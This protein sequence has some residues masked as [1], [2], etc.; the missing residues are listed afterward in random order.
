MA[1]GKRVAEIFDDQSVFVTGFSG[2]L[3]KVLVEK[4]LFST[5]VKKV[6]VL[7]R[8]LKGHSPH[9]RLEKI[10]Q[11]PIYDRIRTT[12]DKILQKL[13]PVVGDL[14]NENLG[15]CDEDIQEIS[16]NVS[17]V[18]HCAATV[19]FDEIL[20]VSVQMNLIGTKELIKLCHK[21]DKLIVCSF[22]AALARIDFL[23]HFSQ[24]YIQVQL[25]QIVI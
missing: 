11:S 19:K 18:F 10:L 14:M 13:V 23:N 16:E 3:G 12:D 20:R 1:T 4:I 6:Y 22:T 24:L 21:M 7:I 17:I 5:N 9:E 25:M 2:F 15:L 8:P